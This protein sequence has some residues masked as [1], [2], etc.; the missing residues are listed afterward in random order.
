MLIA[1]LGRTHNESTV[2]NLLEQLGLENAKIKLKRGDFDVGVE[3]E[4]FGVALNFSDPETYG[5]QELV[6]DGALVLSTVF[7]YSEGV[8]DHRQF[9]GD[10]PAGLEFSMSREE[11]NRKLGRPEWTSPA[12]P[13]DRWPIDGRRLVVRYHADERSIRHISCALVRPTA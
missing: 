11:V 1:A 2:R 9:Q 13:V 3:S 8:E 6:R 10:L 5:M 7:L 4:A 12:L